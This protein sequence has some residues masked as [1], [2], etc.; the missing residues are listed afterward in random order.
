VRVLYIWPEIRAGGGGGY[1]AQSCDGFAQ[2]GEIFSLIM[3][4]WFAICGTGLA[5]M[6]AVGCA[7]VCL[8]VI[9]L[10]LEASV[11]PAY[12]QLLLD[13]I[14]SRPGEWC[15]HGAVS[16]AHTGLVCKRG[17]WQPAVSLLR[18]PWLSG[19]ELPC[20]HSEGNCVVISFM[21]YL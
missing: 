17:C 4:Q 10:E 11:K 6:R 1:S 16:H 5:C 13:W 18:C 15:W 20:L 2:G 12:G 8:T 9:S 21:P 14:L 19:R 7:Y 3:C